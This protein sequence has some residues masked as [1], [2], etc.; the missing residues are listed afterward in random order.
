MTPTNHSAI[1]LESLRLHVENRDGDWGDVYLDNARPSGMSETAFRAVLAALSRKG[2]Y[3]PIDGYAWG[4]V[5][6]GEAP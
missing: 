6:L 5:Q 4:R 2:L 1:V 3:K